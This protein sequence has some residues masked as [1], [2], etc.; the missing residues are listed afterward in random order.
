M[1]YLCKRKHVLSSQHAKQT[2]LWCGDS[3]YWGNSNLLNKL[4]GGEQWCLDRYLYIFLNFPIIGWHEQVLQ[5]YLCVRFVATL[6]L[7]Q[8]NELG[9][10]KTGFCGTKK[11]AAWLM[12]IHR[13][14]VWPVS[15]LSLYLIC[16]CVDDFKKHIYL[17]VF[18]RVVKVLTNLKSY[19]GLRVSLFGNKT[20]KNT[21][22]CSFLYLM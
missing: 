20:G 3:N 8:N 10:R 18:P 21:G 17:C 13:T 11:T 5:H 22:L 2:R 15:L 1:I 4:L 19:R 6:A 9:D 16:K 7:E 12:G 14:R